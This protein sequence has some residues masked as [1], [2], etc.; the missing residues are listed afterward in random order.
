MKTQNEEIS[1]AF[2]GISFTVTATHACCLFQRT[3]VEQWH[4]V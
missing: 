2:T 4:C 3:I 1:V